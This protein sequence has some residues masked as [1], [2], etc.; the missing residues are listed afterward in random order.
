[1]VAEVKFDVRHRDG[2]TI[3]MILNARRRKRVEGD[4][5]KIAV[6]VA[7]DRNRY[8]RELM[9]ARKKADTLLAAEFDAQNLLRRRSQNWCRVPHQACQCRLRGR[10]QA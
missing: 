2:R 6:F 10:R 3:P 5:D 4:F 9:N 7:E 1:M 8:E